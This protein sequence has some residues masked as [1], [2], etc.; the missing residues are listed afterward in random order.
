MYADQNDDKIVNGA[1]GFYYTFSG[2]TTSN[3]Q[4]ASIAERPWCG[5]GWGNNWNN[6]NVDTTG[7]TDHAK[8]T[9]DSRRRPVAGVQQRGLL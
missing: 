2:G 6:A 5:Q 3:P 8:N 1:A 7:L 4:D 9:G